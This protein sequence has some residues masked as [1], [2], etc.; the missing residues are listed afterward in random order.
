[1]AAKAKQPVKKKQKSDPPI[2]NEVTLEPAGQVVVTPQAAPPKP[3]EPKT[4]HE[5]RFPPL[6][7]EA[8]PED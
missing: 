7:P 8:K 2:P 4:I 6:I 3:A 1:M 5:R